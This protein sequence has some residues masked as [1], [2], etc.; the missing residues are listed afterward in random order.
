MKEQLASL[1][2]LLED[3]RAEKE[4]RVKQFADIQSQIE[5]ISAELTEHNHQNDTVTSRVAIEEH[6]LSMRKLDEYQAR[7]RALQKEK[8]SHP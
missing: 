1:A 4:E 2:P 3:L 6:D 7:L 5:K 8:V